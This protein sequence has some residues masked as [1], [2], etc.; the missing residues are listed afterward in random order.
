MRNDSTVQLCT[1]TAARLSRPV[2]RNHPSAPAPRPAEPH[3]H[4]ARI[5]TYVVTDGT[6]HEALLLV[7]S[8]RTHPAAPSP[9]QQTGRASGQGIGLAPHTKHPAP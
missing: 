9:D 3:I 5:L 6:A 1:A 8:N 4:Q 2:P 7:A